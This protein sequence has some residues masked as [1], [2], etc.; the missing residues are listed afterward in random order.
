MKK[1]LLKNFLIFFLVLLGAQKICGQGVYWQQQLD[2]RIDVSLNDKEN[3]IQ[4]FLRLH[5]KNNSP[6][7]LKFIWFHL[8]PNAY[9]NDQTAYSE[10]TLQNGNTNFYFSS[11]EK[12][13]YIN[14]LDFRTDNSLLKTEDH[15]LYIDIVKVILNKPLAPGDSTEITTP[16]HVKLPYC[17]S[18]LG[19]VD[20]SYQLT[21]WYP[22][23]AVYDKK[24]WHPMPYLELGEYYGEFANF[25][26]RITVPE[27]YVVAAT[28][29]LQNESE[30]RWLTQR[31]KEYKRPSK[32]N[33]TG[34]LQ[35]KPT[36]ASIA[37]IESAA[38]ESSN[39]TKTLQYLQNNV[40]D[41][42]WFADKYFTVLYD[43]IQLPGG[44]L[45]NAYSFFS[46]EAA[47]PWQNSLAMIKDAI[48]FRSRQIGEYPFGT[49]SVVRT[50][51]GVEGGM[52]YP[53]ITNVSDFNNSQTLDL[54]IQ[55]EIGH[56]WFYAALAN[57]ERD[58]PWMDEGLNSYYDE[59]YE[60]EKYGNKP[61]LKNASK[62]LPDD[63]N[64]FLINGLAQQKK[65]QAINTPSAE[66]T[67][68]NYGLI[69]YYKTAWWL[70]AL[71]KKV[72]AEKLNL[73]IQSYY[74][75]WKF[76]HPQPE[77]LLQVL[78]DKTGISISELESAINEKGKLLN[79]TQ[80]P[81]KIKP[82]FLFNFSNTTN[83]SY[84]NF[85]PAIGANRYDG[86]MIGALIHNLG[87]PGN[88]LQ[89][90]IAPLFATGSKQVNGIGQINYAWYPNRRI[91][92]VELG[93]GGQRFSSLKGTDSNGL[94]IYGGFYKLA[95][96]IRLTLSNKS[97]RSTLE[98]WIEWK[99]FIIGEKA[100]D[101]NL[102]STDSLFYPAT[103][104]FDSRYINQ[105]TFNISDYR[106]LYPY[107]LNLQ[108]QQGAAFYRAAITGN[109]FLNYAKGGGASVRV[110]G[111][112]FGYLGEKTT[113]KEFETYAFQPKLTAVRGNEDY[114]YSN[115]FFGRNETE[116]FASQQI[117]MRDGGL[118]L[119]TDLFQGLQ[120]RSDN[121]VAAINFN[122]SIP[123]SILPK[124]IP[125]K[126]F[127]DLGTYA[128]V[129]EKNSTA[130]RFL[131][132]GGLQV[133]LAKDLIQIYVPLVYSSEFSDNLK[134]VPEENKFF[135][136]I[137]FSIDIQRFN[138][139]KLTNNKY[140]L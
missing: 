53:T 43:T 118:K 37:K 59:R 18:R 119:R 9:K 48:Q 82:S 35:P 74:D 112:K 29:E 110:F 100:F 122:T 86:F 42:A 32:Q 80:Q 107:D 51:A 124:F 24:G 4:G 10:Q 30:K 128:D 105:L 92:K 131:F 99:T 46:A 65:D 7:T 45:I 23:P 136:K 58:Y 125:V 137:S 2:Y 97:L 98:K 101:Y 88:R 13:G 96:R 73:A 90:T 69:A 34:F 66:F 114:T 49:V 77:D 117:M 6:D 61:S 15:P 55:H 127:L 106:K 19:H 81:K 22:K 89:Y 135:R 16:F 14:R 28:G 47:K 133:S 41:F 102:K 44:K 38:I 5:Y 130:R 113:E 1:I 85:A 71:E 11:K 132:V 108:V 50:I 129:W 79:N 116:G 27:N 60:R 39:N 139:R 94:K 93:L 56:N 17:F 40:H 103:S 70:S 109:Y 84:I 52:E 63:I 36:A 54:I 121:W 91:S 20:Q 75:T 120:G 21:Q 64:V 115:Y 25:D 33:I 12:R 111:A 95:P 87:L 57:N 126:L 104:K 31:N 140:P 123:S 78:H 83:T 72:G 76:K 134:T 8:W 68:T 138:L 67:E 26:V 62:K 3:S